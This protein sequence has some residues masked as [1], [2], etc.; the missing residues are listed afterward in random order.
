[1]FWGSF[2]LWLIINCTL[3]YP[4][5]ILV[6]ASY[7][8]KGFLIFFSFLSYCFFKDTYCYGTLWTLNNFYFLFFYFSILLFFFFCFF[9][10][11]KNDEEA[12]D[13]EVIWQVTWCDITSLE[14]DG[15]VWK[16]MSGHMEYIWW[17]WVRHEADMRIEHGL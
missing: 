12:H 14:H 6:I 2:H 13:N 11:L 7:S 5:V 10:F 16:M 15:R 3:L 1:M 17:P 8:S 9:F 4:Y